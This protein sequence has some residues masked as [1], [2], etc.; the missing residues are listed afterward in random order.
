MGFWTTRISS[1]IKTI[2]DHEAEP[3]G[4]TFSDIIIIM[5]L[6]IAGP[7]SLVELSR[8][9]AFAHPSVLRKIDSLEESGVLERKPHPEDRR[10]KLIS[11]TK[12]GEKL[13]PVVNDILQKVNQ[14]TKE[15]FSEKEYEQ[16][17]NTLIKVYKNVAAE[18]DPIVDIIENPK[19]YSKNSISDLFKI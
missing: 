2:I 18:D 12:Q 7:Q 14:M 16:L 5:F 1:T 11:L 3:L 13:G 15:G 6:S 17:I 8:K 19:K 10:I 9:M 4:F